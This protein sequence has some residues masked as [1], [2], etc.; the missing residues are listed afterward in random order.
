MRVTI[1]IVCTPK[2]GRTDRLHQTITNK[3]RKH[4]RKGWVVRTDYHQED[5]E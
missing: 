3:T 1:T 5:K 2:P 4:A